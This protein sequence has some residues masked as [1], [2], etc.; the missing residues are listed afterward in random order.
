[1][2]RE[3]RIEAILA[4]LNEAL[5]RGEAIDRDELVT[6]HPEIAADLR[7]RFAAQDVLD[8][9]PD[10][11]EEPRRIGDYRIEREVGRGGMGVVYEA[12]QERM[13]RRVALKVLSMSITG[14]AQAIQRFQREAQVAGSLH[15]T[16]IVPVYDLDQ[17]AGDWYYA[18]ELV[19]GRPLSDVIDGLRGSRPTE[20]RLAKTA[21]GMELS[22]TAFGG[23]ETGA[24]AYYVRIAEMFADVADA[25]E[26]AH[27][28]GVM[29]RDIKPSNLLLT[30]DGTLKVVD[31]GLA[32]FDDDDLSMTM[33]GDL[34][35]TPIYMSPEQAMAKRIKLDKRTDIYSLGAT[36]YEVLTLRPPFDGANLHELCSQIVAKDPVLP[37]RLDRRVPR[38]LETIVLK[39]MEK[40]RDKRYAT[41]RELERDL[42]RYAE[43]GVIR[44]RR[45]GW[46]GRSWRK[47]KRH[48]VRSALAAA[49]LFLSVAGALLGWIATHEASR[50]AR[51]EYAALCEQGHRA[52]V[53]FRWPGA[54]LQA[55]MRG[56]DPPQ[57]LFGRAIETLPERPE[58]YLG[59]A[60]HR[61]WDWRDGL[62]DLERAR[63]LGLAERTYHLARA[64]C[65]QR[66][67]RW[68]EAA[69]EE[70]AASALEDTSVEDKYLT[71]FLLTGRGKRK[72]AMPLLT[73][74]IET[75]PEGSALRFL[76]YG[77]RAR[78]RHL[79]SDYAGARD[80]YVALRASGDD[81]LQTRV[82]MAVMWQKLGQPQRMAAEFDALIEE[83]RREH[84]ADEWFLLLTTM[85]GR[86]EWVDKITAIALRDFPDAP[87]LL[88]S[89]AIC[90]TAALT[91]AERIDMARR[92]TG[93]EPDEPWLWHALALV[94]RRAHRYSEAVAAYTRA[95]EMNDRHGTFGNRGDC[96]YRLGRYEDAMR[97]FERQLDVDPNN[98]VTAVFM[99]RCLLA[100]DR[101]GEAL[102]QA[103]RA[104]EI[105]PQHPGPRVALARARAA[106]GDAELARRELDAY[107]ATKGAGAQAMAAWLHV[108]TPHEALRD[109]EYALELATRAL[110]ERPKR[111]K[112]WT[113]FALAR[114]R[115]GDFAGALEALERSTELGDADG[116]EWFTRAMAAWRLGKRDA[117]REAIER[118]ARWAD[119]LEPHDADLRRLRVEA[120][121]VVD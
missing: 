73:E 60:M 67:G 13:N 109:A 35:G 100:L 77:L 36:M 65:L 66:G 107:L 30:G 89:R 24:R 55:S 101:P 10:T 120:E 14:S 38:D 99:S 81:S 119:E 49:V 25:L 41:A 97:D 48:K 27:S 58:A 43:G 16:N 50:R 79:E 51:V 5:D 59:R 12:V 17:Y 2:D 108:T 61:G 90:Q 116:F 86:E 62:D 31:F 8:A 28:E 29:H 71:G 39:A 117:A 118:G 34:L 22:S 80:D 85:F 53:R 96:L 4:E 44:A 6:R 91:H 75:A 18:M 88:A 21:A 11:P 7:R 33:T 46:A 82:W 95:A 45:I 93:L 74:V 103:E 52:L 102:D 104:V 32:R 94:F 76:A 56:Q 54:S 42:R 84:S 111:K 106:T 69:A 37:R 57:V 26:L 113:T 40:D 9:L 63:E 20:E 92:A 1:M 64:F 121:S 72:E 83:V 47:V 110:E 3:E 105:D 23:T 87:R 78:A 112:L 15:H 19:Q 115:T 70:R 98:W 68:D 114:Y